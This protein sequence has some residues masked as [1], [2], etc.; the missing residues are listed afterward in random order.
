[1]FKTIVKAAIKS[2]ALPCLIIFS[3]TTQAGYFAQQSESYLIDSQRA[4]NNIYQCTYKTNPGNKG[5][6][7]FNVNFQGGCPR[8]VLFNAKNGQVSVP[9]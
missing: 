2:M 5:W 9:N 4:G 3:S 6:R 7:N 8:F 1:M